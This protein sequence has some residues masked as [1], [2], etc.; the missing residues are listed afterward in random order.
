MAGMLV[1]VIIPCYNV[2]RFI[3]ECLDSVLAQSHSQLEI[4]CVDNNSTDDTVS[5]LRAYASRFPQK[6]QVLSQPAQGA[7]AARNLGLAAA[8][9]KWIQFLDADDLLLPGKIAHQVQ[10]LGEQA[11]E[12]DVLIGGIKKEF[13]D[14]QT[15]SVPIWTD[16][17]WRALVMARAGCTCSNLYRKGALDKVGGW[18]E[19]RKSSQEAYLLFA[20]LKRSAAVM[21]DPAELTIVRER[22]EGSISVT[23]REGNWERYIALRSEIWQYLHTHKVLDA[24]T[25]L[26]LKQ[27][28]FDTIRM[29]Y[30]INRQRAVALYDSLV[31]TRYRPVVS[32]ST[33]H[34]YLLLHRLLGFRAAER[35]TR[36]LK[37]R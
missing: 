16:N 19:T 28:I 12:P 36:L 22:K 15:R 4:I 32:P 25:E 35:L 24:A 3:A 10:L 23:Q 14:G 2:E 30:P 11:S 37:F 29:L 33:S 18:D 8:K 1:S 9:G 7:P 34:K 17:I 20:L 21:Y 27:T 6:I 13:I 26:A 5:I 31:A